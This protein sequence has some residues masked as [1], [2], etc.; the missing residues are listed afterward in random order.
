MEL[1]ALVS[2]QLGVDTEGDG[3][4]AK[5]EAGVWGGSQAIQ[6]RAGSS[7]AR[8]GFLILLGLLR[9]TWSPANVTGLRN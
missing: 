1:V 5:H 6:E 9:Y 7:G 8:L 3:Q 2:S 4:G